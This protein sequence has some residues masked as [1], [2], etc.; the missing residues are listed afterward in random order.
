MT[1]EKAARLQRAVDT[2]N[3]V[4][5]AEYVINYTLDNTIRVYSRHGGGL[6]LE[7]NGYDEITDLVT[8]TAGNITPNGYAGI[9]CQMSMRT[10]RM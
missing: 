1:H 3:R 8:R 9:T 7:A 2:L 4:L 6:V 10:G 5:N